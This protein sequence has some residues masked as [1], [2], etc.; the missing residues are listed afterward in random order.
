MAKTVILLK[1]ARKKR[2]F[3]SYYLKKRKKAKKSLT[4]LIYPRFS[5]LRILI[6]R[7]T[8]KT[9]KSFYNNPFIYYN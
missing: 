1:I 3:Y 7:K 4:I 9:V 2:K 6:T 8:N 5:F